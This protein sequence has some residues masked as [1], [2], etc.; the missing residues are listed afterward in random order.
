MLSAMWSANL[1][2]SF[3]QKCKE[4]L[5]MNHVKS[6]KLESGKVIPNKVNLDGTDLLCR[7]FRY[8]NRY[9]EIPTLTV[10]L[11]SLADLNSEALTEI[12]FVPENVSQAVKI[13]CHE[14]NTNGKMYDALFRC[15]KDSLAEYHGDI[16]DID[17]LVSSIIVS[18]GKLEI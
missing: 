13:F 6:V 14:L 5:L 9:G 4:D 16:S 15:I 8:E 7:S 1:H 12:S 10:E 2:P 11:F 17:N 18:V 3:F